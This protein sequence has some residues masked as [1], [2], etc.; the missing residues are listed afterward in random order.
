[1]ETLWAGAG[2]IVKNRGAFAFVPRSIGEL[3]GLTDLMLNLECFEYLQSI[4]ELGRSSD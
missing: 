1:M 4:C 2:F 3:T